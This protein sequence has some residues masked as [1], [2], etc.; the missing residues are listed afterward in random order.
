MA[1]EGAGAVARE[2]GLRLMAAERE[3]SACLRAPEA[4]PC[5]GRQT[6]YYWLPEQG[7]SGGVAG[8]G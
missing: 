7:R 3:M 8:T 4:G 2:A 1:V 5:R 6:R